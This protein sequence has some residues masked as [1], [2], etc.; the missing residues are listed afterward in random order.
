MAFMNSSER[1][2]ASTVSA[3]AYCNPFVRQRIELERK[4]LG[5]QFVETEAFWNLQPDREGDH[6]NV[7]RL[8]QR[9][10][11]LAETLRR[12]L[13][14]G[15]KPS[16]ADAQ[17]YE[18]LVLYALYHRCRGPLQDAITLAERGGKQAPSFDFY[19]AFESELLGYLQDTNVNAR[20]A[21]EAPHAFACYY[22]IRRAFHHIFHSIIGGSRPATQLR[23][24]VWQSIFTHD[25]RRYRHTLFRRMGDITTLIVG[26]SGTGKELVA[27]AI[28]LSRYIPFDRK[29]R[30]FTAGFAGSFHPVNLS[31]LSPTLIESDLFGHKRGSFTG[32][33]ADRIGYLSA[34]PPF[35]TVF[36]D[37]IG[38][39][40]GA[41]QV[42]LLRVLQTR[43][44][45]RIGDTAEQRFE[46]KL[47][48][49][50]NRDLAALMADRRFREDLYY[51]L[52]SDMITTPSL[53]ELLRERPEE[54]HQLIMFIARREIDEGA[55]ELADEVI[56][57]IDQTLGTDY[58]WPGNFR[59]LEQCVRNVLIR[60]TYYPPKAPRTDEP[61]DELTRQLADG[62]LT[63]EQMLS[64]YCTI[65]Y[66]RTG[67]YEET[68][69]R[70]QLDRRTVKAKIDMALL[71][72]I[73]PQSQ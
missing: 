1:A 52:C 41:I 26:P 31:A 33:V 72:E 21:A 15:A 27:S 8:A 71:A 63:A 4:A 42:K 70:L 46:G 69:R 11:E 30:S 24:E 19:D 39:L 66:A 43:T 56:A 28:A 64:R 18:N 45:Q 2:F 44:F 17:T 40:D 3:L 9:S 38:E 37:E 36:L 7:S 6:P 49:A 57:W 12:R 20:A 35:G 68:A 16:A 67:N 32:A 62:E 13:D 73:R 55:E 10:N 48:A 65:V 23:S 51:R 29:I 53:Y 61:A 54:L 22:Q 34:C 14:D 59:E 58:A 5:R 25:M 47:M 50:T 60:R